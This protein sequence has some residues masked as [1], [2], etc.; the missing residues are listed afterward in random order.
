MRSALSCEAALSCARRS[1]YVLCVKSEVSGANAEVVRDAERSVDGGTL[2][3]CL[4][5]SVCDCC[6]Y[7]CVSLSSSRNDF[8]IRP[9]TDILVTR[10]S[11]PESFCA[12]DA[13]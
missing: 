10:Y 11:W 7:C 13:K 5:L 6:I 1:W 2:A 4:Y 8:D 12:T 3:R 9:D